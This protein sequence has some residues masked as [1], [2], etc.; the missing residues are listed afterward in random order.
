M[1]K[2]AVLVSGSGSDLQTIIDGIASGK[3]D[4]EI[5]VVISDKPGVYALTRAENAGIATAVVDRKAFPDYKTNKTAFTQ[6][7]I[8]VFHAYQVEGIIFAG[9][10]SI[11]GEEAVKAYKNKMINIHPSLIPSF[12]GIGFYGM[13]VHQA[14]IDYGVKL[15]GVTIHFVDEGTDTGPIIAQRAVEVK[16]DDTA[17]ALQKRVLAAEHELLPEVVALFCADKIKVEDRKVYIQK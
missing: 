7:V 4:G 12:C 9:F 14:A 6:A 11:L 3:I 13:R 15:S 5:A 17:E 10:L 2:L 1:K 16:D 8:A